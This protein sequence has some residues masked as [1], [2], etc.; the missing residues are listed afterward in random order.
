MQHAE[1]L[2]GDFGPADYRQSGQYPDGSDSALPQSYD[3]WGR[4]RLNW[5]ISWPG[6]PD[7]VWPALVPLW[8]RAGRFRDQSS[9]SDG[10]KRPRND[11]Q[12]STGLEVRVMWP[13]PRGMAMAVAICYAV[14]SHPSPCKWPN[15]HGPQWVSCGSRG[16]AHLGEAVMIVLG[17]GLMPSNTQ[18]IVI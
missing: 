6:Q 7:L 9:W 18:Y 5:K 15:R 14:E 10:R 16:L 4:G 3:F 12:P 2:H 1:L 11:F 13:H 17:S 8:A